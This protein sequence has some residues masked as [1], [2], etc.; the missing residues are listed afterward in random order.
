MNGVCGQSFI[1]A[2][3]I[4]L[5]ISMGSSAAYVFSA[6]QVETYVLALIPA[7]EGAVTYF[8][9]LKKAIATTLFDHISLMYHITTIE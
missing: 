4:R 5:V 7:V 9:A 3:V 8:S 6:F 1:D 2:A